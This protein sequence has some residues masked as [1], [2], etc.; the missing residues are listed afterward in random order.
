MNKE[1]R[2]YTDEQYLNFEYF[3]GDDEHTNLA[4]VI[5]TT[6]KEHQCST[7]FKEPHIIPPGTRAILE[8]AIHVDDGRVSNYLCLDCADEYLDEIYDED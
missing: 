5:V 6:R 3:E 8:T 7:I 4:Q 1:T 2:K